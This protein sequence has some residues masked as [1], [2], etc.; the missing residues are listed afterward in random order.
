MALTREDCARLDEADPLTHARRR[1]ILPDGVN[2]LDGNSLGA[3]PGGVA[4]RVE[5]MV[6]QEW[7][8]G[9]VRSWNTAGW[10][11][12]PG[13]I[14]RKLAP[15]LGAAPHQVTVT[16][17]ISVNLFKLLVAAIRL[18]PGR[19]TIVAEQGNFPSDNHVVDSVA[20][21]HGMTVRYVPAGAVAA[22]VDD[23]TAVAELS[24]VSYRTAEI[25]DMAQVTA[26][27]HARGGLAIWDLAH[28]TGAVALALD[29]S[30]AD[31]AV[32]CGYKFLNGGPGAP[33]HVYV[34]QRHH[35]ALDQPLTGWFGHAAPFKFEPGFARADGIRAMLCSTP[36]MLA[37]TAL[38]AALD[39][40]D[41][42]AMHDVQAK[43]RALG[44]LMIRLHDERLAPLGCDLATLRDGARRGNHVSITHAAGYQVMQALIGRGIIGDFR[45]P[46][47]MRFGFGPLYVRHVDV[48]DAVLA[49]EDVLRSGA[50]QAVPLPG[51]DA[52]T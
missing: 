12:S 37:N 41:G 10:Y 13:R 47:V 1:F 34:A 14:G 25:Q 19:R 24:H 50:W 4:E 5:A 35:A 29:D 27:V 11:E 51:P 48:W 31:F 36:Q 40:F 21:M 43:G 23:D 20:R 42:I 38:E 7:G 18:R 16:D 2:Y 9:L 39:A 45:A 6:R 46:D 3:L 17:T 33:S 26:A 30:G 52:V 22:A 8:I 15:L 49:V 28:S 44:D 32:G